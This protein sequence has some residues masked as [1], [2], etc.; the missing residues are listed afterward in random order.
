MRQIKG[1]N[2][3]LL[4]EI[5]NDAWPRQWT[6]EH[7]GINGRK[8]R[9]DCAN[10]S[11]KIAIEIEGGMWVM[12]RHNQ[13]IGM[14]LD[15]DKY[16]LAV[17]EGWRVLRYTPDTLKK[18]PYQIIRDIRTL[19]GANANEAGQ[20]ILCLDTVRAPCITVQRKL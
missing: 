1:E 15:M 17:L 10:I 5:L 20:T 2:E 8:F 12:G 14:K 9:F 19:C 16:N 13:P 3:R 7:K 11:Q 6:M 18:R 4:Y